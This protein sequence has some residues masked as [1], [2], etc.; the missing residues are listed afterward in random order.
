MPE[1]LLSAEHGSDQGNR[2]ALLERVKQ[3]REP[4][5]VIVEI[6]VAINLILGILH[7]A[8]PR[9]ELRL[10][11]RMK[12]E[13]G[14]AL[15]LISLLVL[16]AAVGACVLVLPTTKHARVL[17]FLG[18]GLAGVATVFALVNLIGGIVD[19]E[20]GW[21][22]IALEALGGLLDVAL[23]VMTAWLLF[24]MARR[25]PHLKEILVARP[26]QEILE[27]T[28]EPAWAP[29]EAAGVRWNS[30]REAATAYMPPASSTSHSASTAGS[31][32]PADSA[33]PASASQL[34][35]AQPPTADV[36]S[37]PA[38]KASAD[39]WRPRSP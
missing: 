16:L 27:S 31:L 4:V 37:G 28:A 9:D 32:V 5:A 10:T 23:K 29:R 13:G 15:G 39:L 21:L 34:P 18:A 26:A 25:L 30:A 2:R 6:V 35:S 36:L 11:A 20:Q 14:L 33:A 8:L 19:G 1:P 38:A 22:G 12:A 3:L 7:V 17:A 24:V